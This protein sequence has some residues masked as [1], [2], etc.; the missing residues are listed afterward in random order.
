[1]KNVIPAIIR[2]IYVCIALLLA[3]GVSSCSNEPQRLLF[4]NHPT[5]YKKAEKVAPALTPKVTPPL[6]ASTAAEPAIILPADAYAREEAKA[7]KLATK[8]VNANRIVPQQ[9]ETRKVSLKE[10]IAV[11]KMAMKEVEATQKTDKKL[12][13][14]DR[15]MTQANGIVSNRTAL[16]VILVGLILLLVNVGVGGTVVL[17][18]AILLLLNYL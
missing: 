7:E 4:S 1:M 9:A 10:K 6:T 18:G 15:K 13:K 17:V 11:A 16:I 3:V 2:P 5:E 14:A 12:N 8:L